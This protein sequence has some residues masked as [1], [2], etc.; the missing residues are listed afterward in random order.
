MQE[1]LKETFGS[2]KPKNKEANKMQISVG[3]TTFNN[4]DNIVHLLNS[5]HSLVLEGVSVFVFDDLSIDGT[6]DLV[7]QHPIFSLE[8]FHFEI[9]VANS[10]G[11]LAGRR[12][13]M[14][15]CQTEYMTFIDGD[16]EL[17]S[18]AFLSFVSR[19]PSNMDM[20]MTPYKLYGKDYAPSNHEGELIINDH[21]VTLAASGVGGRI[22]NVRSFLKCAPNYY[23]PRSEDA[24]VNLSILGMLE[25]EPKVYLL[26]GAPFYIIHAGTK[27]K[28][29]SRI[30]SDELRKRRHLYE[31]VKKRFSLGNEYLLRSKAFLLSV[32]NADTNIDFQRRRLLRSMVEEILTPELARVVFVCNDPSVIGGVASRIN[33][34]MAEV[35]GRKVDYQVLSI[36]NVNGLDDS[37]YLSC[38]NIDIAVEEIKSWDRASTA[39]VVQAAILRNFPLV[40]RKA[41]EQFPIVYYGDAQVAALLQTRAYFNDKAFFEGFRASAALSLSKE[42]ISF[43]RQLGIYGQELIANPVN[44]REGNAYAALEKP[45]I[46]YVGVTDFRFKATDRMVDIAIAAKRQGL[47]PIHIFTSDQPNSP[48]YK[49]LCKRIKESEVSDHVVVHLSESNKEKIYQQL[50]VLYVPS[51]NEAGGIVILEAMSFGVPVVGHSYAP[52]ISETVLDGEN[53]YVFDDFDAEEIVDRLSNTS[54]EQFYR[55]SSSAFKTHKSYSPA[56]HIADIEAASRVALMRFTMKNEQRVF[57]ILEW[58]GPLSPVAKAS[59][60][61]ALAKTTDVASKANASSVTKLPSKSSGLE[62]NASQIYALERRVA[63]L[64]RSFPVRLMKKLS[65]IKKYV[66][67][68]F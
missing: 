26:Q 67:P 35:F 64:E 43:Q 10:G 9:S 56:L 32:I 1:R 42:D 6:I 39:V 8:K 63:A 25:R 44:Q 53:G 65:W 19:V 52:A 27:S 33:L 41:L 12:A 16:D 60:V 30:V 29:T 17:N 51:R 34:S 24:H 3:V 13:M 4:A 20:V 36:G 62:D 55:M 47:P 23:V 66:R 45:V 14:A 21:T 22:Y 61:Q 58:A 5:L 50:S 15:A 37:R 57:P 28:S 31:I 7:R 38:E 18:D 48:D 49:K 59:N 2:N 11:P 54:T 40:V 46:G 68:P